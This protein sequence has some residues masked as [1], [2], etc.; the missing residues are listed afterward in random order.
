MMDKKESKWDNSEFVKLAK[1]FGE[2]I[3]EISDRV[4]KELKETLLN[5]KEVDLFSC[6]SKK[7]VNENK[8]LTNSEHFN[9]NE[10]LP[11]TAAGLDT[12]KNVMQKTGNAIHKTGEV[13]NKAANT[14]PGKLAKDLITHGTGL[15]DPIGVIKDHFRSGN[16]KR[17]QKFNKE[18]YK[19]FTDVLHKN[20]KTFADFCDKNEFFKSEYTVIKQMGDS[21]I[22]V[23]KELFENSKQFLIE[24]DKE[25]DGNNGNIKQTNNGKFNSSYDA[26]LKN[27]FNVINILIDITKDDKVSKQII[28]LDKIL[29]KNSNY[30][31]ELFDFIKRNIVTAVN[32]LARNN[33]F[34]Q[35]SKQIQTVLCTE[36][37]ADILEKQ[38][39]NTKLI[40][41]I[42]FIF[43]DILYLVKQ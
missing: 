11:V 38:T 43:L 28:E 40:N 9:S 36:I 26:E 8:V 27:I 4:E 41:A 18:E 21:N 37:C 15:A 35:Y 32:A 29:D 19:S 24:L 13:L 39:S 1:Q 10:S 12:V 25:K 17:I 5:S 30:A 7:K 31:T 34:S 20:A 2:D 42:D 23:G 3:A 22:S 6:D 16:P 14:L 33:N